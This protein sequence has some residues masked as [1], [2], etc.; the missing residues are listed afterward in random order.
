MKFHS[1]K[2]PIAAFSEA[3]TWAGLSGAITAGV[4]MPHPYHI[5]VMFAGIMA[6]ILRDPS[7]Q[8]A[9]Q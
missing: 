4:A 8:G 5:P 6:V 1:W 3:S 2:D 9:G 7:D